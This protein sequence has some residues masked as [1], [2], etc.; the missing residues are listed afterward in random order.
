MAQLLVIEIVC[1][2]YILNMRG[3]YMWVVRGPALS[4]RF[5]VPAEPST[6]IVMCVDILAPCVVLRIEAAAPFQHRL[7]GD[8][9]GSRVLDEGLR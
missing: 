2:A 3:C 7:N 6:H 1:R 9:I 5:F 4:A 8:A